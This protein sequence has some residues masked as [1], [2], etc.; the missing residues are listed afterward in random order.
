MNF[1][2]VLD[3]VRAWPIDDQ[4]RL[5]DLIKDDLV[6]DPTLTAAQKKEIKRRLSRYDADPSIGISSEQFEDHMDKRLK[7]LGE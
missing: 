5:V 3:A 6:G 1:Q 4:E 7:E 2:T